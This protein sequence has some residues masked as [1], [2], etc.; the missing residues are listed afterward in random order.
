MMTRKKVRTSLLLG[1][2][3]MAVVAAEA[4]Q[5]KNRPTSAHTAVV[6][7]TMVVAEDEVTEVGAGAA[8]VAVV[9][10]VI[11]DV[12]E[13]EARMTTNVMATHNL[14]EIIL[15]I[16]TASLKLR[17]LLHLLMGSTSPNH[18][19]THTTS[20]KTRST[21]YY[22]LQQHVHKIISFFNPCCTQ[23]TE[24]CPIPRLLLIT[25]LCHFQG[26]T[27]PGIRNT[28]LVLLLS[29]K[30]HQAERTSTQLS[31][32]RPVHRR[33]SRCRKSQTTGSGTRAY[34]RRLQ[35]RRSST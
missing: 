10:V 15:Q 16:P 31:F 25:P 7:A 23:Q 8:I 6:E 30:L 19:T 12:E 14:L 11:V 32:L 27:E 17:R 9:V 20:H 34:R 33:G 29:L 22:H 1:P 24:D 35:A 5:H 13:G 4:A 3:G 21:L 18:L 28:S 2:Q 26:T